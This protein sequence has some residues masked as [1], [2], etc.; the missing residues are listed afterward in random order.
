MESF[1]KHLEIEGWGKAKV[2]HR[3]KGTEC[4]KE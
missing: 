4:L 2:V 1:Q 3:G